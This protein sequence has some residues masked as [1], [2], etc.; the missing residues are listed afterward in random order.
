MTG[1]LLVNKILKMKYSSL[2]QYDS[3]LRTQLDCELWVAADRS[4][5]Y[6]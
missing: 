5:P 4:S 6:F 1:T 2:R 3:E